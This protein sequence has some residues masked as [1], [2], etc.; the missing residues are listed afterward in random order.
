MHSHQNELVPIP[1]E[2][3]QFS[4][5]FLYLGDS[6]GMCE[7]VTV[8]DAA[9]QGVPEQ[10]RN[11]LRTVTNHFSVRKQRKSR[12]ATPGDEPAGLAGGDRGGR[13]GSDNGL[14]SSGSLDE[15]GLDLSSVAMEDSVD[16]DAVMVES[17]ID[18][19]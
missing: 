15:R 11:R 14:C 1:V 9:I 17:A 12:S 16:G 13:R 8:I 6:L 18:D 10:A 4:I 3:N 5:P 19:E 2:I 7:W